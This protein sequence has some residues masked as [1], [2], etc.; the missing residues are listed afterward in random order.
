MSNYTKATASWI[1]WPL[2]ASE[3]TARQVYWRWPEIR[4]WIQRRRLH[5]RNCTQQVSDRSELKEF[6][7][8][9]GVTEGALVMAHTSTSGLSLQQRTVSTEQ[10]S[11][12]LLVA[13]QLLDDLFEL[14]G[15]RGTL[16][17][18]THPLFQSHPDADLRRPENSP[19][20]YDPASSPCGV[21][22]ANELFWRSSGVLRSLHPYNSLAARG[23]LSEELLRDNLNDRKPLP[24]GV[25]SAYYRF[26]QQNGL[27][28]SIGVPLGR[29]MTLMH[30]AE[31]VRDGDWPIPDFFEERRYIVRDR[32]ME[33]EW[34]V[35]QR[36]V[37]YG[38]FC[39]CIRKFVRDLRREGIL[40][41]TFVGTVRVD[42]AHSRRVFDY[43]MARNRKTPYPYYGTQL[44]RTPR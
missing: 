24:H 39:L 7:R 43:L 5:R 12:G 37:E 1:E 33:K 8:S 35:R 17:M 15:D 34:T 14:L 18:P 40:S 30:T 42:W 16:L 28:V 4:S 36:R 41:E 9:I 27:I 21:G 29:Y 2:L 44:V 11:N 23:P 25:D 26:C 6:L 3:W 20:V 13:R 38:K 19:I 31:D 10:P 22:L 32:D